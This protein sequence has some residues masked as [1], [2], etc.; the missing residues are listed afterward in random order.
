M[1]K[2]GRAIFALPL[3]NLIAKTIVNGIADVVANIV[4]IGI[5][6]GVGVS[7]RVGIGVIIGI[8]IAVTVC[9]A[10]TTWLARTS[11]VPTILAMTCGR[12]ADGLATMPAIAIAAILAMTIAAILAMT[13]AA[14]L[15]MT[16]AAILAM[17]SITHRFRLT[18]TAM[19]SMAR[20]LAI[21]YWSA[22][23]YTRRTSKRCAAKGKAIHCQTH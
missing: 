9:Y 7:I 17:T 19:T 8:T 23:T 22:L 12:L 5:G 16:I 20:R 6:I 21:A 3:H 13:I 10:R 15:A 4:V 1:R 14:I 18:L 11:T 2:K